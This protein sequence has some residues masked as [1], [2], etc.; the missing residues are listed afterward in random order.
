MPRAVSHAPSA[1]L[2]VTVTGEV[3]TTKRQ[4]LVDRFQNDETVR[5]FVGQIHAAGVGINLTAASQVVFNDLDWVPAN[6]WQAE[7]RAHR[8]G[9]AG[10][11]NVTYMVARKTL[12]E[13]VRGVLETKA[14]L[15]DDVVEG[16][17]LGAAVQGDVL[18]E[19]RRMAAYLGERA[20]CAGELEPEAA[21]AWLRD[22]GERLL[23]R[24]R[25]ALERACP[26]RTGAGL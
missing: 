24:E 22:V 5:V 14:Q 25:A 8:I 13:F 21:E 19:L 1:T 7:D 2:C 26:P 17:A 23:A 4:A 9:Q 6:H 18:Q 15:V 3:P 20:A 10:T 16:R 11:V 12:E